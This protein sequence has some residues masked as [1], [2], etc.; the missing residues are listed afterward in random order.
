MLAF[1]VGFCVVFAGA[2]AHSTV[3]SLAT[4]SAKSFEGIYSVRPNRSEAIAFT[5]KYQGRR[6]RNTVASSHRDSDSD[7]N[8][9]NDLQ[10]PSI[11][12]AY[13]SLDFI[14]GLKN[15]AT[16][17][18]AVAELRAIVQVIGK[19]KTFGRKVCNLVEEDVKRAITFCDWSKLASKSLHA[20]ISDV[21]KCFPQSKRTS[22]SR[23]YRRECIAVKRIT[24]KERSKSVPQLNVSFADLPQECKF[25]VFKFV[26]P[27][28]LAKVASTCRELN[29]LATRNCL[30]GPLLTLTF[31][32]NVWSNVE[33][34]KSSKFAYHCFCKLACTRS[35]WLIPWKTRRICCHGAIRWIAPQTWQRMVFHPGPGGVAW[36]ERLSSGT[37]AFLT[38]HQVSTWLRS[39]SSRGRV[40]ERILSEWKEREVEI[41]AEIR[42]SSDGEAA[43]QGFTNCSPFK[44]WASN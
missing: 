27:I 43:Q 19:D 7:S 3:L 20:L 34:S 17:A 1:I 15:R 39:E 13:K 18:T 22:I 41:S 12:D 32:R 42:W 23:E 21:E 2:C 38:P 25:T 30:W 28:T 6:W 29:A 37:I 40:L 35:D 26:D 24:S 10:A 33:P 31:G 4:L 11:P 8:D 9:G 16:Y 14:C 5:M 44:F 36:N